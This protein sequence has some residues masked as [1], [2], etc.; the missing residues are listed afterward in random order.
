[1]NVMEMAAQ[2]LAERLGIDPQDALAGLSGLLG[3]A[4]GGLDFDRLMAMTQQ[5]GLGDFL[6]SLLGDREHLVI[7][8]S[9]LAESLGADELVAAATTMGVDSDVLAGGL[10]DIIPRV[11]DQLS[12][13]GDLLDAVG[14]LGG[15]ADL[16]KKLL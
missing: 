11:I 4:D 15:V 14:G 13:G 12:G 3:S 10:S 1:M 9:A 5:G 16:A 2:M 6:S 8:P 7:D